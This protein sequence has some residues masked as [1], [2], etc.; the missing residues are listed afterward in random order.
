MIAICIFFCKRFFFFNL[1]NMSEKKIFSLQT[2]FET[3]KMV[4]KNV[5]LIWTIILY[6]AEKYGQYS[7]RIKRG[8]EGGQ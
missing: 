8:T 6:G 7:T 3:G 4:N 1:H 5:F 2:Q